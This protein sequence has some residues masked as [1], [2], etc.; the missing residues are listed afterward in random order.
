MF[1]PRCERAGRPRGGI[2]YR[3]SILWLACSIGLWS[4]PGLAAEPPRISEPS[5]ALVAATFRAYKGELCDKGSE[6]LHTYLSTA[7][8]AYF[9][10]MLS[11]VRVGQDCGRGGCRLVDR[12]M[13]QQLAQLVR[14]GKGGAQV[15]SLPE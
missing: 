11:R 7:T 14:A 13:V 6:K 1:A 15:P 8:L 3:P 5:P 12:I 2:E 4:A 10:S 9:D